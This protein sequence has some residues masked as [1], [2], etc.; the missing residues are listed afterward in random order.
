MLHRLVLHA[1]VTGADDAL[2]EFAGVLQPTSGS[3]DGSDPLPGDA[4]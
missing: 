3:G 2:K 4:H 1:L